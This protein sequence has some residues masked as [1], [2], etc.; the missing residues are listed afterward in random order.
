LLDSSQQ[1]RS[2][3]LFS[4]TVVKMDFEVE[5]SEGDFYDDSHSGFGTGNSHNDKHALTVTGSSGNLR[6]SGNGGFFA[7]NSADG[8]VDEYDFDYEPA[9]AAHGGRIATFSPVHRAGKARVD[10]SFQDSEFGNNRSH[11]NNDNNDNNIRSSV[12]SASGLRV[13]VASQES[14]LDKAQNM[15]SRY[16]QLGKKPVPVPNSN[17]KDRRSARFDEDDISLDEEDNSDD[18]ED[19]NLSDSADAGKPTMASYHDIFLSVGTITDLLFALVCFL[20]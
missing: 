12:Q 2:K 10:F 11:H 14:A 1:P 15:L 4:H 5:D 18:V 16:S 9:M 8:D 7:H 3:A 20:T 6:N 13:S 17:F 19:M